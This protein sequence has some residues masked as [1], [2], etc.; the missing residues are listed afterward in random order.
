[1]FVGSAW[2]HDIGKLGWTYE[3][4]FLQLAQAIHRGKIAARHVPGL[5]P[6]LFITGIF[7]SIACA[8]HLP[9]R[10]SHVVV[11]LVD[12]EEKNEERA[13]RGPRR[14]WT[15]KNLWLLKGLEF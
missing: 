13:S 9:C 15:L 3:R 5:S 4:C 14:R 11:A 12:R 8:F 7:Q 1:M 10:A 6:R 2:I